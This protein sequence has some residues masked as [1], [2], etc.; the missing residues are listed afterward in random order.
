[1]KGVETLINEKIKSKMFKFGMI[2]NEEL[3]GALQEV[4]SILGREI[5]LDEITPLCDAFR[6]AV[7]RAEV[8]IYESFKKAYFEKEYKM[9]TEDEVQCIEKMSG[10]PMNEIFKALKDVT[11]NKIVTQ[12]CDI[13]LNDDTEHRDFD[14][15]FGLFQQHFIEIMVFVKQ[16]N[17]KNL[18]GVIEI[19]NKIDKLLGYKS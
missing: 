4:E 8:K 1:M 7:D 19:T 17:Y 11:H 15:S 12:I 2:I 6:I 9:L 10:K 16:C 13:I 14:T 18:N 5:M 3:E